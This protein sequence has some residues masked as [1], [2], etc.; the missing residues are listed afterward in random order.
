M[1]LMKWF[2]KNNNKIMAIVV[3][4]IM[5]GFIG[6]TYIQQLSRRRTGQHETEAHSSNNAGVM[7]HGQCIAQEHHQKI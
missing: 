7:I 3:I 5:F 4:V 2:R 1:S 6:G